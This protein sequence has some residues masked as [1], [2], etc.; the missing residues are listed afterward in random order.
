MKTTRCL[1]L[2]AGLAACAGVASPSSVRIASGSYTTGSGPEERAWAYAESSAAVTRQRWYDRWEEPPQQ[3][4]VTEFGI[5]ALPV[6]QRDYAG[7]VAATGHR[8][9]DIARE[10]YQTQGF[11]VHGYAKVEPYRWHE[12][13]PPPEKHDRPVVLVSAS[14]AD[15]YC[16]WQGK[17]LPTEQEWEAACRGPEGRR[18]AWGNDW[19]APALQL[20]TSETASVLAHPKGTTPEGVSD[21]L[22]NVFEWTADDFSADRRVLR[23]CSWDDAPGTCRCAFRHGRPASSRHILIGFRCAND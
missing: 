16:R 11:L 19:N 14:D 15:A 8:P 4:I 3:A 18:F 12:G 23:G 10:D 20:A 13:Q 17:R 2:A 5:D 9:P 6:T 1:A 22:G 21:L 7:F